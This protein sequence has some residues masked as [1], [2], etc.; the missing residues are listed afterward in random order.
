MPTEDWRVV[1]GYEGRYEVSSLGR[2]RN[3]RTGHVLATP[4]S[5]RGR[6]PQVTL[7]DGKARTRRVHVLVAE[8][9]I[10]PR[11][12]DMQ[13]AHNDGNSANNAVEN[14][15]YATSQENEADKHMHG[16]IR[17]GGETLNARLTDEE[18]LAMRREAAAGERVEALRIKYGISRRHAY[19]VIYGKRWA[20][21]YGALQPPEPVC[22]LCGAEFTRVPGAGRVFRYC[23]RHRNARSRNAV[24]LAKQREA[25]AVVA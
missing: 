16:T 21:L 22:A 15:R 17:R 18:V 6:Y 13:I 12:A 25:K 9:F 8:A 11:P 7:S 23:E 10:G 3:S 20:H 24:R 14:L 1:V 2:V 4:R 19:Q 5:G